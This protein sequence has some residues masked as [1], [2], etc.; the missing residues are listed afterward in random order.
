MKS[1]EQNLIIGINPIYEALFASKRHCYRIVIEEG[2]PSQ[3]IQKII[4][5]AREKQTQIDSLP[6]ATFQKK[7][8][9]QVHQ[10]IAGY[11][12]T[13]SNWEL[14]DLIKI[15]L[16][17]SSQPTLAILDGVQDPQ[18]LGAIIRSAEILGIHGLILPK[19]GSP[20]LNETVAKCSSGAVEHLPISW[21][22]NLNHSIMS[23]KKS[24]F[25]VAGV[26]PEGEMPCYQYKFNTPSVLV[27]GGEGKGI[28]PLLKK[29][30]D[31]TLAIPM[32]GRVESLNVA[33]ASTVLFYEILRQ[34]NLQDGE[35]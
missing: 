25:W 6:K 7:F 9:G 32:R 19:H 15:S 24:G 8:Q 34:K 31:V 4:E 27:I 13:I 14:E 22:T 12:S 29:S 1:T 21:V 20:S 23:L 28:R 10:G 16:Q 26:L 3:R 35:V 11:F 2:K 30:C 33:S 18:N 5:A 17:Q